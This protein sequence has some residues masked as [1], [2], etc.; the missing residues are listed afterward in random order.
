MI[1]ATLKTLYNRSGCFLAAFCGRFTK[2]SGAKKATS[3]N[4]KTFTM[5]FLKH[6]IDHYCNYGFNLYND[7]IQTEST[8]IKKMIEHLFNLKTLLSETSDA[9][10]RAQIQLEIVSLQARIDRAQGLK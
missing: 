10:K 5:S 6:D 4:V 7:F 1:P 2:C 8:M 9:K 3:Q